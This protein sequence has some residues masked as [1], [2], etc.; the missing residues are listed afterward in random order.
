[1][2]DFGSEGFV[3]GWGR[4][5]GEGGYQFPDTPGERHSLGEL[6]LTFSLL[7]PL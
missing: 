2:F 5:G 1:M 6:P 7:F 4:G 3:L